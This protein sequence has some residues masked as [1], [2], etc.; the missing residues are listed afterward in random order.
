M[1]AEGFARGYG[2]HYA[3]ATYIS[4]PVLDSTGRPHAAITVGGP[5]ERFTKEDVE[6]L[7][8]PMLEVIAEMNSHSSLYMS[9]SRIVIDS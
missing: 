7:L 3:H 4:F 6:R 5:P 2:D 8:P 9:E 1:R